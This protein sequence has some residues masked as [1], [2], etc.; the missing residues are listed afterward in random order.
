MNRTN[1][2]ETLRTENEQGSCWS[3]SQ[4]QAAIAA[5]IPEFERLADQLEAI[6]E[7]LGVDLENEEMLESEP[8]PEHLRWHTALGAMALHSE[9]EELMDSAR[10]HSE[11]TD[12]DLWARWKEDQEVVTA[13]REKM[14]R[15]QAGVLTP[16]TDR[17]DQIAQKV[18]ELTNLLA[19]RNPPHI[20]AEEP[21]NKVEVGRKPAQSAS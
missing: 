13:F 21:R 11:R 19:T 8:G 7:A 15:A 10:Y 1:G 3:V 18:H 2:M 6:A 4:A 16:T 20:G 14:A 5:L 12:A 17:M 9:L